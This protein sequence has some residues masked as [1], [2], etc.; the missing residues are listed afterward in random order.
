V[1]RPAPLPPPLVTLTTDFGTADPYVGVLKGV[2]LS[3]ERSLVVVDITHELPPHRIAPAAFLL[4]E[5]CPRYPAGTIHVAVVDPGVGSARRP[6][7]LAVGGHFYV[8]PDNGIFGLLLRDFGRS[9]AWR[10]TNPRYFLEPEPGST[11]H[12]RDIFAPAA[13]HLARGVPPEEFGPAVEDPLPLDLP[14]RRAEAGRLEGRVL[15]VD[16]FGNCIT[17]LSRDIIR[18]WARGTPFRVRVAERTLSGLSPCYASVPEGSLLALYSSFG[19]LEIAGNQA[20]AD[21]CLGIGPGSPVV[22]EKPGQAEDS[23]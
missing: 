2:L 19:T 16:R 15:W 9:G 1:S 17:D 22:L 12:G 21:R 11:F 14:P 5:V 23:A 7:L 4:R 6:L 20:R 8:G 13:A 10:L 18:D 3:I